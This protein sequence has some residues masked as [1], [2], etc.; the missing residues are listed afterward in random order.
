MA[1]KLFLHDAVNALSGTFPTGEQSSAL[2]ATKPVL[3]SGTLRTMSSITGTT[4]VARSFSSSITVAAQA[5]FCAF[6]CSDTFNVDQPVGGGNEVITLNI[7]NRESSTSMNI[8]SDLRA[9]VYVWRPSSGTVVGYVNDGGVMTGCAEPTA[10]LAKRVNQGSVTST[11]TVSARA[12]D[13]LICEVWQLFVQSSAVNL[14]GAI[15]YD[16]PIQN[17]TVNASVSTHASFL[18][19]PTSTLTFGAPPVLSISCSFGQTLGTATL[20]GVGGVAL[21]ASA[22]PTLATIG[23]TTVG[24]V[25]VSSGAVANLADLTLSGAGTVAD[26]GTISCSFGQSLA[27]LTLGGIGAVA[28]AGA[29]GNTLAAASLTG[30]ASVRVS[31]SFANTLAAASLTGSAAVRVSGTFNGA[32]AA[33][34]VSASATLALT[35]SFDNALNS[36]TLSGQGTGGQTALPPVQRN[37]GEG[38]GAART[39]RKFRPPVIMDDE[40]SVLDR[41]FGLDETPSVSVTVPDRPQAIEEAPA[42][43]AERF[44]RPLALPEYSDDDIAMI[45]LLVT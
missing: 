13:V 24:R 8:G 45:L 6:F 25:A 17:T 11:V 21:S 37:D 1:T 30:S 34:S 7:A 5:L 3:N 23:L 44:T 29:F 32:A 19:F 16:G 27:A 9:S 41:V 22:A 35:I 2:T 18:S 28:L 15:F 31:G 20:A 12:G 4:E 33:A 10:A 40:V 43:T 39:R 36:L 14:S 26:P 38:S 42:L